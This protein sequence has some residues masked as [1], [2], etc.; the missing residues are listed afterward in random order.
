MNTILTLF[1]II[2]IFVVIL[3]VINYLLPPDAK[4]K[5]LLNLLACL[6]LLGVMMYILFGATG[7]L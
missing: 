3:Y 2:V 7:K 1:I 4:F 5:M 6:F